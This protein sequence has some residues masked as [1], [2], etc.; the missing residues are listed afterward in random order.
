VFNLFVGGGGPRDG[1]E[2]YGGSLGGDAMNVYGRSTNDQF[3][4][5]ANAAM[6]NGTAVRYEGIETKRLVT[7]GG[8]DDVGIEPGVVA[9]VVSWWDPTDED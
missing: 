4:V 6:V 8:T 7:M 1:V 3:A 2:V 9:E 5:R